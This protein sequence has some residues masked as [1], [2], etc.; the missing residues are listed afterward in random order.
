MAR[1]AAR[2]SALGA[3]AALALLV[4]R[5]AAQA[6]LDLVLLSRRAPP[7]NELSLGRHGEVAATTLKRANLEYWRWF[8]AAALAVLM[9]EW[10]WFHRRTA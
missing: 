5:F 3:Q 6:A 1:H 9:A 2:R 4:L 7:R 10:W 8:A